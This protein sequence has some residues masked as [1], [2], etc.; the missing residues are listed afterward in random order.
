MTRTITHKNLKRQLDIFEKTKEMDDLLAELQFSTL[1]LPMDIGNGTFS[2]PLLETEDK[3]YA[4]VFTDI[5]EY[6]K[7]NFPEDFTLIPYEFDFYL[8]L[9]DEKIDGIVIDAEGERFPLIKEFQNIIKPNHIFD[10]N[11][12]VFTLNEIKQMKDSVNNEELEEFLKDES[13]WWD[14]EGLMELLLKSDL[15][16]VVLSE[17]DISSKAENGVISLHDGEI[18]PTALMAK[19]TEQYVL[20]Y[21][22]EDEVMFKNNPMHPYLQIVNLPELI[23]RLLLD[24]LDGIILNEN[25]QNITIPREFLLNFLKDF[26]SPNVDKYDDYAFVLDENP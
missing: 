20:I 13:N 14:Y 2:F 26:K 1:L 11:P 17:E 6:N 7:I 9:L 8:T 3:M 19:A 21:T 16:T 18:L 24:D 12:Q 25:S 5:Y 15:F 23:N 10:Y 4:P 22:K